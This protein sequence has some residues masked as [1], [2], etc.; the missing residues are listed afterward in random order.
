[1]AFAN[2][3]PLLTSFF[4][5]PTNNLISCVHRLVEWKQKALNLLPKMSARGVG[6]LP[7][8]RYVRHL[9]GSPA[10]LKGQDP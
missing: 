2:E 5:R 1:M 8:P 7:D 3:R 10:I 9:F 4:V 6:L